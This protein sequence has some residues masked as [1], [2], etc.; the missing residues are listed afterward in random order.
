MVGAN[1][2]RLR[3]KQGLSQK[4][5]A[6]LIKSSPQSVSH[7]EKDRF[8]PPINV[9]ERLSK[10]FGVPKSV[11][12]GE[13]ILSLNDTHRELKSLVNQIATLP[14]VDQK[15][16]IRAIRSLLDIFHEIH[17]EEEGE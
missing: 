13:D 8:I 16:Y 6:E 2:R 4:K 12:L 1:I 7:W 17:D 15:K 9:I 11:V 10:V 3:I 14:E 5:L